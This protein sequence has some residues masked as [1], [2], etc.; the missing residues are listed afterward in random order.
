LRDPRIIGPLPASSRNDNFLVE[1]ASGE[2]YVLRR[3][4]RNPHRERIEFQLRFQQHLLRHGFPTSA[5]IATRDGAPMLALA[6]D[7]YA[8]STY[9]EGAEYDHRSEAQ[10]REAARC[11]A[12]FQRA[13]EGFE[14]REVRTDTI[15]DVRRWW[16]DGK[17][18]LE[19]LDAMFAGLGVEAELDHLHRW[20]SRVLR[21]WPCATLNALRTAWVHGDYHGRNMVF[22]GDRLAGLF[23]F[24]VVHSGFRIED[25]AMA[26]F[27]FG[28][29][30]RETY[31]IRP[32]TAQAFLDQYASEVHL[33]Q[34]ERQALPMMAILVHAR[35]AARYAVRQRGG[36]DPVRVLRTHIAR[37]KALDAQLMTLGPSL[38][39]R[40]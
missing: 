38:L 28:R 34:L 7:F 31:Q 21:A 39:G 22:A 26:L 29:E 11:L 18:E 5:V 36:E 15:P 16:L 12:Q 27:T 14:S 10:V 8:L 33:T 35:T 32:E 2:R 9:V 24:D 20:H 4:R 30:R 37:M 40:R 13:A 3:Y 17:E 25:A 1:D 23:D 6:Q 19:R